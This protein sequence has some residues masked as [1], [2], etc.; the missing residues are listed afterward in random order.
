MKR[1]LILLIVLTMAFYGCKQSTSPPASQ[2]KNLISAGQVGSFLPSFSAVDL[3]GHKLTSADLKNKVSVIDFWAT[4]CAPC[5]KE[6]PG[7]Q[8]LFSKYGS[9]GLAVIGFKVDVMTDSEDPIHFIRE[10]GVR[11]PIAIGTEEIRNRFG[12][13]QGLP[14]TLIYDRN[15]ILRNKVIGFEYTATIEKTIQR[16]L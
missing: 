16:F 10:L 3:Q 11:Y 1:F 14:T 12:G 5:R 7:Y 15:G 9:R 8:A 4:W 2:N 13:L 6:M